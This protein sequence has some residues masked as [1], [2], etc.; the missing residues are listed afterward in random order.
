VLGRRLAALNPEYPDSYGIR[1][2]R[3]GGTW[4][5]PATVVDA[6]L[7]GPGDHLRV[8]PAVAGARLIGSLGYAALG[9]VGVAIAVTGRAYSTA[10]DTL[11]LRLDDEGLVD[12]IAVSR[13]ALAVVA[14]DPWERLAGITVLPGL[15]ALIEWTAE[16]AH[17]TLDRLVEEVHEATG[18]GR[19]PL[20][21]LVGDTVLGPSATAAALAGRDAAE[22]HENANALLDALVTRGA[23]ITRR[24]SLCSVEADGTP[25]TRRG[26]CCMYYREIAETCSGCPLTRTPRNAGISPAGS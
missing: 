16:R 3:P 15:E 24:G 7:L 21:N 6:M 14:G 11:L 1:V 9:R 12:R 2:A 22:G 10:P 17:R 4:L 18:Y 19:Q 26:A 5:S 20:W 23:L 13:P 25:V 8:S